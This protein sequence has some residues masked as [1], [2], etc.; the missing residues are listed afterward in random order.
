MKLTVA[1][2][3][4]LCLL[5]VTSV[6]ALQKLTPEQVEERARKAD[7]DIW[8]LGKGTFED[9]MAHGTWLVYYGTTWC[10]FC[11][12]LTP[13][14]LRMQQEFTNQ[15]LHETGFLIT[16][17]DCTGTNEA[18][19]AGKFKVD[20]YPTVNLYHNGKLVEEYTGAH[21]ATDLLDYIREKIKFYFGADKLV[22]Q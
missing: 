21:E 6:S 20:S 8:H 13:R 3:L 17:V 7:E 16:K 10:K 22:Q 9:R 1:S 2:F 4:A 14:W 19:C 5:L 11:K 12:R 15:K 18:W